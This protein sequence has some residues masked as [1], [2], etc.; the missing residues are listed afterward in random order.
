[1]S[2]E[3]D[4]D[5]PVVPPLPPDFDPNPEPNPPVAICG[6]CGMVWRQIMHYSC[7]NGRCPMQPR[8]R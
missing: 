2:R 7:G 5:L 3:K 1:M 4:N 8:L 6:E